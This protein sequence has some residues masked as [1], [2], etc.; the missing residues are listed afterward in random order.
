MRRQL[1][2]IVV[3]LY[4][5]FL[6]N[7][8]VITLDD[9]IHAGLSNSPLLK[10]LNNQMRMNSVDSLLIKANRLPQIKFNGLMM[11]APIIHDYGYSEAITNGANF[12]S[13]LSAS[14]SIFN[15]K[16]IESQYRKIGLQNQSLANSSRISEKDLKKAITE[17]YL[18]VYSV[19]NEMTSLKTIVKSS[20]DEEAILKQMM[21]KGI[22]RQTD[23]LSF[24]VEMQSQELDLNDLELKYIKE[25]SGLKLLCG[26][27][28]TNSYQ[29]S[30]PEIT[31]PLGKSDHSPFFLHFM[32]D[33]LNI[34]NEKTII[35]RNYKPSVN[36]LTDAGLVNNDPMMIY[37][38]FGISIGMSLTLPV[39]DG[40]QRKLNYQKLKMSE[41]TRK[42]YS[43]F[44]RQQYD[45][46]LQQLNEQLLRT[47]DIIPK[48]KHQLEMAE[49]IVRQDKDLLNNGGI[50]ITD[51]VLA[52]KNLKIFRKNLNQYQVDALRIINEINY[53]EE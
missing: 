8:Q 26:I 43:D 40:N 3:L 23:Y 12:I 7:A 1:T 2:I 25:L 53:W 13:V 28:D 52:L 14:Q 45:Q 11:Y 39:Y 33:S 47:M 42:G 18:T 22:Y 29:L 41:E 35:D 24:L 19:S 20:H 38:N 30:M 31:H 36:W 51:Y 44:F 32:I 17:Q 4:Q 49:V 6:S 27:K 48:L 21:E 37:K 16:S 10:D 5:V 15:N 34:Q 46:Q 9:F 50:T